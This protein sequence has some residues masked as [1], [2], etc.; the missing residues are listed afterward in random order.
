ML[1]WLFRKQISQ[2]T[3]YYDSKIEKANLELATERDKAQRYS[4]LI[5]IAYRVFMLHSKGAEIVGI[6]KN[7]REDLFV[8]RIV[9]ESMIE[10]FLTGNS[11]PGITNRPR[12][13]GMI[14]KD[15]MSSVRQTYIKIEDIQN[16]DN[17][18]GNGSILL[19]Y[20]IREAQLR[21]AH[22]IIGK[23]S[24]VDA[25]HFDRSEHF[26]KKHEFEVVFDEKRTSG[27]IER[28]LKKENEGEG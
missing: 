15:L 11:Y 14:Y 27:S 25:E 5:G 12:I 7:K 28:I 16:E 21:D 26:Y 8:V 6:E 20:L 17:D 9:R 2:I 10:F 22:S 4:D 19:K 3:E 13:Y 1:K 24:P 18:I 23:L